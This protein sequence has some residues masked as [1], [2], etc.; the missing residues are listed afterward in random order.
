MTHVNM[1]AFQGCEPLSL[2]SL[3]EQGFHHQHPEDT[4]QGCREDFVI[5]SGL[6]QPSTELFP[7]RRPILLPSA[8]C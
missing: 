5:T 3:L 2:F 4:E 7:R 8:S 6:P 1:P